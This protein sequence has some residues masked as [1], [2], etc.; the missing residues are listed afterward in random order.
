[1]DAGAAAESVS[2]TEPAAALEFV[3]VAFSGHSR[4]VD[5]GNRRAAASNLD[6]AFALLAAA[7]ITE[8]RLLTGAE[9]G[10]D[11]LAIEAWRARGLGPVHTVRPFLDHRGDLDPSD[12]TTLLPGAASR[13][14]GRSPHLAQ[15][16]WLVAAA[17][18]LVVFWSGQPPRGPGGTGDVVRLALEHGTPVLWVR[19][20][21]E[22]IRLIRPERLDPG[23]GLLELQRLLEAGGQTLVAEATPAS[24][25]AA[26]LEQG[27]ET[28]AVG[29]LDAT[30]GPAPR[31]ARAYSLFRRTLGG[32]S[33]PGTAH[34]TPEDLA[35]E[36]GFISLSAVRGAAAM[37]ARALAS[38]HRSHQLIL[39]FIAILAAAAGSTSA[40]APDL[41]PALVAGELLLAL[42]A[43]GIW[44]GSERGERHRRW[45]AARKLAEDLRLERAA[46]VVG[47]STAPHGANSA[48]SPAAR[49]ARRRAG[50]PGGAFDAARVKAWGDWVVAELVTG[51]VAYHRDQARVDGRISHRVHQLENA[52]FAALIVVLFAYLA[53]GAALLSRHGH[54]PFWLGGLVVMIGAVAPAIGAAGLALEATLSLGEQA[55]RSR[56][57]ADQ[58]D[59]LRAEAGRLDTLE[60]LQALARGAL[61]LHRAQEDQWSAEVGR[62]RLFRGG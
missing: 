55:R 28:E 7:G 8:A 41:K 3:Q 52:I 59:A 6:A 31:P 58:L 25:R 33:R 47:I 9:A 19:P 4:A 22:A 26:L 24:V 57:L 27:L 38:I 62:R 2:T 61:R 49:R 54:P 43:L 18:I 21:A 48:S 53:T 50:L 17:D 11:R 1:M 5:L 16:R 14:E 46:W 56:T 60:R 13:A 32:R 34:P 35:A 30:L 29:L 37:Q 15:A 44:L 39:L 36:P 10:A 12:L 51:Q 42:L 23:I 40:L 45:T 20:G